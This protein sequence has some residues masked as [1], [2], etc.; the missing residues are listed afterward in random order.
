MRNSSANCPFGIKVSH[1]AEVLNWMRSPASRQSRYGL[2]FLNF[3]IGS[4]QTSFWDICRFLSRGSGMDEGERRSGPR[5]R[6][7]YRRTWTNPRRSYHRRNNL[8]EGFRR[9]RDSDEHGRRPSSRCGTTIWAC[10]CRAGARRAYGGDC[11]AGDWSD[12]LRPRRPSRHVGSDGAKLPLRRCRYR[13]NSR[14]L[15]PYRQ[16]CGD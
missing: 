3:A 16:L 13:D 5:D 6:P 14:C 4:I 8:E 11:C 7:D 2:D 9:C 15:R 12:Q 1:Y 10:F